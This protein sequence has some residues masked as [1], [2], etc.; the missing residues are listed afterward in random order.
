MSLIQEALRRQQ[1]EAA[2]Q[3]AAAAQ[4]QSETPAPP[5][6]EK[7]SEK[8]PEKLSLKK[9]QPAQ[10]QEQKNNGTETPPAVPPDTQQAETPK[11]KLVPGVVGVAA[12]A[13]LTVGCLAWLAFYLWKTMSPPPPPPATTTTTGVA[14]ASTVPP[15]AST[16]T[17]P[18]QTTTTTVPQTVSQ[19]ESKPEVVVVAP[20]P[21]PQ[22]EPTA[23]QAQPAVTTAPAPK[24][25]PTRQPVVW[26]SLTLTG[27]MGRGNRGSAIINGEVV[28]VG[29]VVKGVK[30]AGI[31]DQGVHLEYQGEKRFL[32]IGGTT[33]D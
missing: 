30:I 21:P 28:G 13:L 33:G 6:P 4:Q 20:P 16:T 8:G 17:I 14:P 9:V 7:P 5:A 23:T 27:V 29:E 25:E 22:P 3:A 31:G 10:P 24:V 1:A 32:K 18:P 15:P 12:L 2:K 19:P 26:P 11:R